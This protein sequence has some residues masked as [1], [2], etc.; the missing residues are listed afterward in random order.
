ML[1]ILSRFF[2]FIFSWRTISFERSLKEVTTK[3]MP[4]IKFVILMYKHVMISMKTMQTCFQIKDIL[5]RIARDI[6]ENHGLRLN[7][8]LSESR[9]INI[10]ENEIY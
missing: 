4:R 2:F 1:S 10:S 8:C 7:E 3:S 5:L 6:I 9:Y